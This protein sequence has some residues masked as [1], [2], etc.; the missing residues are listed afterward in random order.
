MVADIGVVPA[1]YAPSDAALL[2]PF[3]WDGAG[4]RWFVVALVAGDGCQFGDDVDVG[5]VVGETL[6]EGSSSLR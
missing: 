1:E 5:T 6:D 4:G 3:G 2:D